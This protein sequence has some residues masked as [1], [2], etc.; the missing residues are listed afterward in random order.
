MSVWLETQQADPQKIIK[1][2]SEKKISLPFYLTERDT[3]G[4]NPERPAEECSSFSGPAH[5]AGPESDSSSLNQQNLIQN[6]TGGETTDREVK[7]AL[8]DSG[9]EAVLSCWSLYLVQKVTK[10][11]DRTP[12]CIF[13]SVKKR[14][15]WGEP[16]LGEKTRSV[17]EW[18]GHEQAESFRHYSW[19]YTGLK[20]VKLWEQKQAKIHIKWIHKT[21]GF[22]CFSNLEPPHIQLM[23]FLLHF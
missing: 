15:Q 16:A 8:T 18:R 9:R 21:F 17:R 19:I 20:R 10:T 4:R 11:A 2:P 12:C 14:V 23:C 6:Q 1:H 13:L 7:T 5:T 22:S 3:T